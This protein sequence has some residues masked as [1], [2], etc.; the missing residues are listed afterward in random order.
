MS[1]KFLELV[2]DRR[3]DKWVY[4]DTRDN[5]I[6]VANKKI[7]ANRYLRNGFYPLEFNFFT[8]QKN[9]IIQCSYCGYFFP[10]KVI[11]RDHIY[12]KSL[13]G[14]ATTPSC[15]SCNELKKNLRP[16]E[17]AIEASQSGLAYGEKK[18]LS[19]ALILLTPEENDADSF[20]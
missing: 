13:G 4:L 3:F 5:T 11:T 14:I 12:P 2:Y 1:L 8:K 7:I 6:Y 18:D 17:W 19:E 15:K 16:I 9:N 20:S 10:T